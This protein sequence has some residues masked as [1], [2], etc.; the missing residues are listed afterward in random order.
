MCETGNVPTVSEIAGDS[1]HRPSQYEEGF[2]RLKKSSLACSLLLLSVVPFP[3]LLVR[4]RSA[5]PAQQEKAVHP[6]KGTFSS[7]NK[8][9]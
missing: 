8:S 1:L 7:A 2:K 6:S 3:V 9:I 4:S 5:K